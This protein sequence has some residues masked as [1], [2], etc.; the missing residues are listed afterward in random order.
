[1]NTDNEKAYFVR[2]RGTA[3]EES[4]T[5]LPTA[6]AQFTLYIREDLL[7]LDT[8][9]P[10]SL[11]TY[12]P[13]AL[14]PKLRRCTR[15]SASLHPE[16]SRGTDVSPSITPPSSVVFTFLKQSVANL[17]ISVQRP[18]AVLSSYCQFR[19]SGYPWTVGYL[20]FT[21]VRLVVCLGVR[22]L[23]ISS[24]SKA[25]PSFTETTLEDSSID[26]VTDASFT[27]P[28]NVPET[29]TFWNDSFTSSPRRWP[30]TYVDP[31]CQ[32][33]VL[34]LSAPSEEL[35][36]AES[37]FSAVGFS[38]GT[39]EVLSLNVD[40]DKEETSFAHP[41]IIIPP[42]FGSNVCFSPL[43]LLQFADPS[44][45]LVCRYTGHLEMWKLTP[46]RGAFPAQLLSRVHFK[47]L[48]SPGAWSAV[49]FTS[50]A[51]LSAVYDP[52]RKL[53]LLGNE[54]RGLVSSAPDGLTVISVSTK[55]PF[56]SLN[57][58]LLSYTAKRRPLLSKN[59]YWRSDSADGFLM[60]SLSGNCHSIDSVG[61][62]ESLLAAIHCSHS[63]SVWSFPACN[64]LAS[65]LPDSA[66]PSDF[67]SRGTL[68]PCNDWPFRV[69]WWRRSTENAAEKGPLSAHLLIILRTN[70][71]LTLTDIMTMEAHSL[72]NSFD[73]KDPAEHVAFDSFSFFA[74]KP[75][76]SAQPSLSELV[77]ISCSTP[78]AHLQSATARDLRLKQPSLVLRMI[79]FAN[80]ISSAFGVPLHDPVAELQETKLPSQVF[81]MT[82]AVS[83]LAVT[84]AEEL[85]L[86]RIRTGR[87]SDALVLA[88][89]HGL[90]PEVVYQH[91]WFALFQ[92]GGCTPTQFSTALHT[93]L[94]G[95]VRRPNWV[96]AESLH[97]LPPL[98]LDNSELQEAWKPVEFLNAATALLKLGHSRC[99]STVSQEIRDLFEI[100]LY[101]VEV[102]TAVYAEECAILLMDDKACVG[103]DSAEACRKELLLLRHNSPLDIGLYYLHSR[104]YAAFSVLA[105]HYA[106]LL[107]PNILPALSTL[108]PTEKPSAYAGFTLSRLLTSELTA[109][110]PPV[111]LPAQLTRD[112]EAVKR[113]W[114][115]LPVAYAGLSKWT[116]PGDASLLASWACVRVVEIDEDS[117]LVT[118]ACE[119]LEA[120][121]DLA[122][123]IKSRATR[124]EAVAEAEEALAI[125]DALRD[126]LDQ[127][128]TIVYK[129]VVGFDCSNALRRKLQYEDDQTRPAITL[130]HFKFSEFRR[131]DPDQRL[132]LLMALILPKR[133]V[134][135][136][137][138]CTAVV[139]HLLPFIRQQQRS[140]IPDASSVEDRV[141]NCLDHV[142][143]VFGLQFVVF[144]AETWSQLKKTTVPLSSSQSNFIKATEVIDFKKCI[145]RLL[146][147]HTPP[148]NEDYATSHKKDG[149][150]TTSPPVLTYLRQCRK[151]LDLLEEAE[152]VLPQWQRLSR[153]CF[154]LLDLHDQL[155][156]RGLLDK[157]RFDLGLG[158]RSLAQIASLLSDEQGIRSLVAGWINFLVLYR[159]QLEASAQTN[160]VDA[161]ASAAFVGERRL[162]FHLGGRASSKEDQA[163]LN[164]KLR[165][166]FDLLSASL[167]Q[168]FHDTE[169]GTLDPTYHLLRGLLCSGD[170][171][172]FDFAVSLRGHPG[173]SDALYEAV[174]AYFSAIAQFGARDPNEAMAAACIRLWRSTS[175]APFD[176]RLLAE[177]AF[178]AV[179]TFLAS[180]DRDGLCAGLSRQQWS[181]MTPQERFDL[182][183]LA[184]VRLQE[185][186]LLSNSARSIFPSAPQ[187]LT[188]AAFIGP[189]AQLET[190]RLLPTGGFFGL[191]EVQT[192]RAYLLA[193]FQFSS[194]HT[195]EFEQTTA[196]SG[197]YR[198]I[199]EQAVAFIKDLLTPPEA[200]FWPEAYLWCTGHQISDGRPNCRSP[201]RWNLLYILFRLPA[202]P[203]ESGDYE[204]ERFRLTL[205]RF[206]VTFAP[207]SLIQP[208]SFLQHAELCEALAETCARVSVARRADGTERSVTQR[209]LSALPLFSTTSV[210][211]LPEAS[212]PM[213]P[214]DH[215][216][217]P[218]L[219]PL[220][221]ELG[222]FADGCLQQS[223]PLS[224]SSPP[225]ALLSAFLSDWAGALSST[226]S[227]S[228]TSA[229]S[230][231]VP[232]VWSDNLVQEASVNLDVALVCAYGPPRQS[233]RW[234]R[235]LG[236]Q[237]S[238]YDPADVGVFRLLAVC[239][240]ASQ[241]AISRAHPLPSSRSLLKSLRKLTQKHAC[242][243]NWCSTILV[244]RLLR[245]QVDVVVDP[246]AFQTNS[247]LRADTLCQVASRNLPL[248]LLLSKHAG[249]LPGPL[250]LSRLTQLLPPAGTSS[251]QDLRAELKTL[252][253]FLKRDLPAHEL[254][255][256]IETVFSSRLANS[257]SGKLTLRTL[258]LFLKAF[259]AVLGGGTSEE[260][261]LYGFPLTTH[262]RLLSPIA[263]SCP[264]D[265]AAYLRILEFARTPAAGDGEGE[266]L[267]AE[268]SETT[269]EA[270]LGPL[271]TSPSVVAAVVS[272]LN[273]LQSEQQA[274]RQRPIDSCGLYELYASRLI[275]ERGDAAVDECLACLDLM[276]DEKEQCTAL[277]H[278]LKSNL[279][280]RSAARLSLSSRVR[281]ADAAVALAERRQVRNT[282]QLARL[283]C[284]L[285]SMADALKPLER[286]ISSELF[287]RFAAHDCEDLAEAIELLRLA[288]AEILGCSEVT[289]C[290]LE[291]F[292]ETLEYCSTALGL[293]EQKSLTF[294]AIAESINQF[295]TLRLHDCIIIDR[296]ADSDVL[297]DE[298]CWHQLLTHLEKITDASD[299]TSHLLAQPR[300]R[301]LYG[302][303]LLSRCAADSAVVAQRAFHLTLA[304][305]LA[306]TVPPAEA[307]IDSRLN[308]LLAHLRCNGSA[309]D[310][311]GTTEQDPII[312]IFSQLRTALASDSAS[313][314]TASSEA[315]LIQSL[316]AA[317][318]LAALVI[319]CQVSSQPA[320]LQRAR[321]TATWR[322]WIDLFLS[323][324][325]LVSYPAQLLALVDFSPSTRPALAAAALHTLRSSSSPPTTAHST[326]VLL[327]LI[328]CCGE[329][330][331][332]EE[333][334]GWYA[335]TNPTT[336]DLDP[337]ACRRFVWRH[338]EAWVSLLLR[339]RGSSGDQ[340]ALRSLVA[341]SL[342]ALRVPA[343]GPSR[344]YLGFQRRVLRLLTGAGL[345]LEAARVCSSAGASMRDIVQRIHRLLVGDE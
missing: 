222:D 156:S 169:L 322:Q 167:R 267:V 264:L 95:I 246:I 204:V 206:A 24:T 192:K 304:D 297:L 242:V 234:T 44:H 143:C 325:T 341:S 160:A 202:P 216:P 1:M 41:R 203:T 318:Q 147:I 312:S 183:V 50:E 38:N 190:Q 176:N 306:P 229:R 27:Y 49:G 84:S 141:V 74:V 250:L 212:S 148:V 339:S 214:K 340:P 40:P 26:P 163:G 106:D 295:L 260:I 336:G 64:L 276:V 55:A 8:H 46:A 91:Q 122:R 232:V 323:N 218:Y 310:D 80:T 48:S 161:A 130:S 293:T 140:A 191:S 263:V 211:P 327:S 13:L 94:G 3:H 116:A 25:P 36:D 308:R 39:I 47:E 157:V 253:V 125:L 83:R 299:L 247:S 185:S 315:G 111:L 256:Y 195:E 345:W 338:G 271:L 324:P 294:P 131:L 223:T 139:T 166:L 155:A 100:R 177:E 184:L 54:Y 6:D 296:Q 307:V 225:S 126:E 22:W 103:L 213:L 215:L 57:R 65:I 273:Q 171:R 53:L 2:R 285:R 278:W 226:S 259:V 331:Q 244:S 19:S 120:V 35:Q 233:K 5:Q 272:L 82:V 81:P 280:G 179:M 316:A 117:G 286:E 14:V 114:T 164:E 207:F 219:S 290:S 193:V 72:G 230:I 178:L 300:V 21:S 224:S 287:R 146:T 20:S 241:H 66:P 109:S 59:S 248:A 56:F 135:A 28:A 268:S 42:P 245:R 76:I 96:L 344:R 4:P 52:R 99:N 115:R 228:S 170:L 86:Y 61:A 63:I 198:A 113:L 343:G 309:G 305:L 255:A 173:W 107:I 237:L 168:L 227:S 275:T 11:I 15:L 181:C 45:L 252:S 194:K 87:F 210:Q 240:S 329:L 201:A 138:V 127:F 281:L 251:T 335:A 274:G 33:R 16:G 265:S 337:V 79:E 10:Q 124:K 69:T 37:V 144:M 217:I 71:T 208:V 279:F 70:G 32:W 85:F 89:E 238:R 158:V 118:H 257:S 180:I 175:Q 292:L 110:S 261:L 235:D 12:D 101:Q 205:A 150:A 98:S 145:L 7:Q 104:R 119:L 333:A 43:V 151:I 291:M 30:L 34:A 136:T 197:S 236:T 326:L 133:T 269:A 317:I 102:L 189:P 284:Y 112:T 301:Q 31:Y 298:D 330:D 313:E 128:T 154:T 172:L 137:E 302:A 243:T 258:L 142:A 67:L 262:V 311:E 162:R 129:S 332:V 149:D 188:P 93:A 97:R 266:S 239:V 62:Y 92:F 209:L 303:D 77:V 78:S 68:T 108:P 153:Y 221:P 283:Q 270:I 320:D 314:L 288:S 165:D 187:S 58:N 319:G 182:F 105:S 174:Q 60:F 29:G 51:I 121:I 249:D 159:Q 9:V 75:P 186:S 88:K 254:R 23:E 123:E 334:I 73:S 199:L 134:P 342:A 289:P 282:H 200:S 231:E 277:V 196:I 90:D 17:L 152:E 132:R 220:S 18:S 328:L 321:E